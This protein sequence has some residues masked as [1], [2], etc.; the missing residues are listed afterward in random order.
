MFHLLGSTTPT[1][2]V[3]SKSPTTGSV[4]LT[5]KMTR[6]SGFYVNAA[7]VLFWHFAC[8]TSPL[9]YKPT[10]G[11]EWWLIRVIL[12]VS[13]DQE[14]MPLWLLNDCRDRQK[15][16]VVRSEQDVLKNPAKKPPVSYCINEAI[17]FS[18]GSALKCL[19][20]TLTSHAGYLLVVQN[21]MTVEVDVVLALA[22]KKKST[23]ENLFNHGCNHLHT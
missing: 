2:E 13:P 17:D 4:A 14:F 16:P 21:F 22:F 15:Y 9:T 10:Q 20:F 12:A 7:N 3:S 11:L 6:C 5:N 18:F 8:L 19:G 23:E 1:P